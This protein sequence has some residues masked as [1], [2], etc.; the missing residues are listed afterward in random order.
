[1]VENRD[2]VRGIVKWFDPV[3]GYGFVV[4]EDGGADILL[5]ANVLRHFG[6]N[7]VAE[8]API[9]LAVQQTE[10]GRQAIE[11]HDIRPPEIASGPALADLAEI[12]PAVLAAAPLVPS[13]VKWFD[14]AKGF[15]F[16]N[17]FG[18]DADVFVHAE[19]LRR[20]GLAD[21][22]PG[23]AVTLRVIDGPRGKMATEVLAWEA[24]LRANRKADEV[25]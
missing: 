17:V 1:M 25:A 12:D 20:S 8:G 3:R 19:V 16:A 23:E 14:R 18:D 21:L 7:S 6:Q 4:A 15:G 22:L 10:R 11:V 24:G 2:I 9:D 13:R 5:H